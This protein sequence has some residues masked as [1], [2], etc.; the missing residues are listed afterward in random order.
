M[1]LKNVLF[2]L[3]AGA[4]CLASCQSKTAEIKTAGINFDNDTLSYQRAKAYVKNYE[5]HAGTVDSVVNGAIGNKV[6][7]KPDTRAIWFSA[8]RLEALLAKIRKE[9]GDGIRFYLATYDTVYKESLTAHIPPKKYWGYNTLVMVSTRDSL[10]GKF[11]QDYY[12]PAKANGMGGGFIIG[13]TPENRGEICPPPRD[14][15]TIGAT[16]A[17]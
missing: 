17:P 10:G 6:V 2:V 9:N 11:H 7:K 4:I 5:K 15:N 8:D 13:A 14:C 3:A 12:G 16:L 1:T